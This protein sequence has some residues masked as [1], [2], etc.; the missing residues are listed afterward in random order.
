MASF[1]HSHTLQ[2]SVWRY[3]F[4]YPS[5][6]WWTFSCFPGFTITNGADKNKLYMCHLGIYMYLSIVYS[7]QCNYWVIGYFYIQFFFPLLPLSSLSFL[8]SCPLS[9]SYLL[10]SLCVCFFRIL[11]VTPSLWFIKKYIL[12]Y[13]YY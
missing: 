10:F 1:L 6:Y 3:T 11:S 2:E 7:P 9:P 5:Y 13:I 8:P 12:K 4:I